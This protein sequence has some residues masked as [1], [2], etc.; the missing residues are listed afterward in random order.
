[1][2]GTPRA[3]GR[4]RKAARGG[5]SCGLT[6]LGRQ[7]GL[8]PTLRFHLDDELLFEGDATVLP[9]VN[10]L[11]G[12][13]QCVSSFGATTTEVLDQLLVVHPRYCP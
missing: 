5:K 11:L 9:G 1:M 8:E 12:E 13:P 4:R 6:E 2:E 3:Q 10:G 7:F